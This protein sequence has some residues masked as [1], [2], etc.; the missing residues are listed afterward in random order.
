MALR[1]RISIMSGVKAGQAKKRKAATKE[2]AGKGRANALTS[3]KGKKV[4]LRKQV[5]RLPENEPFKPAKPTGRTLPMESVKPVT[6]QPTRRSV[7]EYQAAEAELKKRAG[8]RPVQRPAGY[9]SAQQVKPAFASKGSRPAPQVKPAFASKGSRP[10]PQVIEA[11]VARNRAR[12]QGQSTGLLKARAMEGGSMPT[13][14]KKG[15]AQRQAG[16]MPMPPGY[17]K[18][19]AGVK[20]ARSFAPGRQARKAY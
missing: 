14:G 18:K 4:G 1:R 12:G 17:A 6:S 9:G 10:A 13:L 15:S 11:P 19:I 20:S 7:S 2:A 3:G 16:V 5:Y 8:S